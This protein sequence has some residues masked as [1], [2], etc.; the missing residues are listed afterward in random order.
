VCSSIWRT[1][2]VVRHRTAPARLQRKGRW[3]E[4]KRIVSVGTWRLVWFRLQRGETP[5]DLSADQVIDPRHRP[6]RRA[7]CCCSPLR[8]A[9]ELLAGAFE[10]EIPL[11]LQRRGRDGHRS[12]PRHKLTPTQKSASSHSR[13][14]FLWL[15]TATSVR[16]SPAGT[17][18]GRMHGDRIQP[19][20]SACGIHTPEPERGRLHDDDSG[21]GFAVGLATG[22]A[23]LRSANWQ[24]PPGRSRR[25][26]RFAAGASIFSIAPA[27]KTWRSPSA[28][29]RR[30]GRRDGATELHVFALG[31]LVVAVACPP[32]PVACF[33]SI[34]LQS[35]RAHFVNHVAAAATGFGAFRRRRSLPAPGSNSSNVARFAGRVAS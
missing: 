1:T 29:R 12:R 9:S 6:S 20:Q 16:S 4:V 30:P 31:R 21:L 2:R 34:R 26:T 19:R 10:S 27:M 7:S 17:T 32:L 28:A 35:K 23:R 24:V 14:V 18:T 3:L 15:R 5:S 22:S 11:R 8:L 13:H 33:N 25:S